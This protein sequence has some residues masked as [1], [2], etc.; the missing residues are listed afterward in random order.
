[1]TNKQKTILIACVGTVSLAVVTAMAYV[2][3]KITQ[4]VLAS[5]TDE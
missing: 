4:L 3:P 1:M 5:K 2:V